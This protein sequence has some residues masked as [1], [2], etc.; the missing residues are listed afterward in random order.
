M[1]SLI[2]AAPELLVQWTDPRAIG[3]GIIAIAL[4]GT[5][6]VLLTREQTAASRT[7]TPASPQAGSASA[8]PGAGQA[9]PSSP[10][11]LKQRAEGSKNPL[12]GD[13]GQTVAEMVASDEI[14]DMELLSRFVHDAE[15][16]EVGETMT[17]TSEEVVIKKDDEFLAVDPSTVIQKDGS[18]LLDPNVDWD[19][20]RERGESWREANLDRMEYDEEGLPER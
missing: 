9:P 11:Q 18:L 6:A 10:E 2:E 14:D 13:S 15:G 8:G 19:Q 7:S 12:A 17:V 3:A 16:N 20:A 1:L 4:I 5:I